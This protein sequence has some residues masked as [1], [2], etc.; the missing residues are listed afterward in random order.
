MGASSCHHPSRDFRRPR[1]TPSP[2][3]ATEQGAE[4]LESRPWPRRQYYP[5]AGEKDWL[6]TVNREVTTTR[7]SVGV[8]DVSNFGKIE[9][10]GADAAVFLDRVC[11]N[12][13]STLAVGKARY[14]LLLR[15]DGF[16]QDDGTVARLAPERFVMMSTTA[17]AVRTMQHLEFCHQVLWPSLDVQLV[18]VCVA[19]G[20]DGS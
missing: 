19:G 8:C 7:G 6:D 10:E 20:T 17:N 4:F 12:T 11:A 18:C 15:E 13:F 9:I 5:R 16:V 3:W 1:L 14:A 2:R